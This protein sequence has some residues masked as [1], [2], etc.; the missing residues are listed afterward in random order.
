MR[1][2]ANTTTGPKRPKVK[3]ISGAA[4]LAVVGLVLAACT[5]ATGAVKTTTSNQGQPSQYRQAIYPA[6][7]PTLSEPRQLRAEHPIILTTK[8]K[9]SGT[10]GADSETLRKEHLGR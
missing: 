5:S 3:V 6:P 4:G 10:A 2:Q 1:T 9:L 8:P 7:S